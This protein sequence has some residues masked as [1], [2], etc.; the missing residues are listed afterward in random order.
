MSHSVLDHAGLSF[1]PLWSGKRKLAAVLLQVHVAPGGAPDGAHLAEVLQEFWVRGAVPMLLAVDSPTL[2][3]D[4]LAQWREIPARL[5]VDDHQ[6]DFPLVQ[7]A[8]SAASAAHA[9][10]VW[11]A[12][13]G[14]HWPADAPPARFG[15]ELVTPDIGSMLQALARS[16]AGL[17]H[18]GAPLAFEH[19]GGRLCEGIASARL[20]G[21]C[22]DDSGAAAV[23]DW[24]VEDVVHHLGHPDIP[25]DRLIVQG[26]LGDIAREAPFDRLE[27]KLEHDPV[28]AWRFLRH[29]NSAAMGLRDPLTSL[30]HALMMLGADSLRDWLERQLPHASMAADL[31]PV[32]EMA[33]M[34]GHL[35]AHL[36]D[37]GGEYELRRELMLCGVF[38]DLD[39]L[40]GLKPHEA[41]GG[42]HL[43]PA[44]V[45][46]ILHQSGPY[47]PYLHVARAMADPNT[48]SL[49]AVGEVDGP[50]LEEAN[51]ALLQMLG[52]L[53]CEA[54][55]A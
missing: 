11:R 35:L 39:L 36:V 5:V 25:V 8:V 17:V 23:V 55:L 2:L 40:L 31:R 24:P 50:S 18:A 10:L 51:R 28:L 4:L 45:D 43:P 22:L 13:M 21:P 52:T 32:R 46:A 9:R 6:A 15:H 16:N 34:R 33:V 44:V 49:R 12:P 41:L 30:R 42:G 3:C 54:P 53:R 20:L 19:L 14:E 26:L 38:A 37:A 29:A 48:G 7:Q 27:E 47:A 1:Q